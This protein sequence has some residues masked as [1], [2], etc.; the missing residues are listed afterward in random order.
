MIF[1]KKTLRNFLLLFNI[2]VIKISLVEKILWQFS[3]KNKNIK[4]L[5]IGANDGISF[6][7]LYD[8]ATK[9]QWSG[10]VVEPLTDFYH[11]LCLNYENF[12]SIKPVNIAI[13][14]NLKEFNLYRVDPKFHKDLPD[15]ASGAASF[16]HEHLVKHGVNSEYI[17]LNSVKSIT[18]MELVNLYNL[19][20]IDYLQ[21][22]V[23]GMDGDIIKMI[24]FQKMKPKLIRFECMHMEE[25]EISEIK[26]ILSKQGYRFKYDANEFF[27]IMKEAL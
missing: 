3:L 2:R 18:L 11:K 20:D 6:D 19:F 14:P 21:I 17:I 23:E 24:D 1:F 26:E 8:Y 7:C 9:R 27:A 25:K 10:V 4:F 15:W 22:D 16:S 13:H 5:Q 12:S